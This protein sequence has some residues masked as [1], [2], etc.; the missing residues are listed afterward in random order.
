M[1]ME[2]RAGVISYDEKAERRREVGCRMPKRIDVLGHPE[3]G[4]RG[5]LAH[6]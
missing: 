4:I 3:G 5:M 6:L 1:R 2:T